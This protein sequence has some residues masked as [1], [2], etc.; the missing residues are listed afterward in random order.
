MASKIVA[1]P[2]AEKAEK[3]IIARMLTGT[4]IATAAAIVTA[5]VVAIAAMLLPLPT[6]AIAVAIAVGNQLRSQR[7]ARVAI[8]WLLQ[9]CR[10]LLLQIQH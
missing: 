4:P 10:S 8:S 2:V 3:I 7:E 6:I 1:R 5:T 9:L